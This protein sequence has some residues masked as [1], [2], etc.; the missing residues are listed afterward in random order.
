MEPEE[1]LLPIGTSNTSSESGMEDSN[2]SLLEKQINELQTINNIIHNT[3]KLNIPSLEKEQLQT[4]L[5]LAQATIAKARDMLLGLI[6]IDTQFIDQQIKAIETQWNKIPFQTLL[7]QKLKKQ[8]DELHTIN[9]IINGALKFRISISEREKLENLLKS[10]QAT[11]AKA[12]DMLLGL[13]PI[14]T[15]LIDQ[16]IKA[17]TERWNNIH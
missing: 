12:R 14:D 11:V 9:N 15:E 17:I 1:D 16:Q 5:K 3:L 4:L 13:I 8:I 10:A 7:I 6:L 2:Q